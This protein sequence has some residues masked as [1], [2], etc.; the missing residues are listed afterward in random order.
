MPYYKLFK[1]ESLVFEGGGMKGIA[2]TEVPKVLED[3]HILSHIKSVAG[4]SAGSIISLLIALR[5][6]PKSIKKIMVNL[7]F[8]DFK[9]TLLYTVRFYSL[10][11]KTG[12]YNGNKFSEWLKYII[13]YKLGDKEATFMDLYKQNG[14]ELVVTG[15]SLNRNK[16]IYFSYKTYPDM[17]L[18]LAVRI[19]ISIPGYFEVVKYDNDIFVDGG[20]INNYPIW[21]FDDPQSY[22]FIHCNVSEDDKGNTLGFKLVTKD[23]L[24]TETITLPVITPPLFTMLYSLI[25]SMTTWIDNQ[26]KVSGY[27]DRTVGIDTLG[28]K[29]TDFNISES[30][31]KALI[32][33]GR[34]ITKRILCN[35]LDAIFDMKPED[36]LLIGRKLVLP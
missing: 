27:W 19:S 32:A 9:D 12:M 23:Q 7:N 25:E 24:Q 29:S 33:N 14:I 3:F 28:I 4:T 15:T 22:D 10:L 20:I 35:K 30:K 21:V 16:T 1:Y 34:L 11:F 13:Q 31:K 2:F 5:Y 36:E 17:P 8:R 6:S 26:Y 18:W